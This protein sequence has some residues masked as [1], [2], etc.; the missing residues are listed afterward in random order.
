MILWKCFK[1]A[2]SEFEGYSR[3]I[4]YS[5]LSELFLRLAFLYFRAVWEIMYGWLN[6]NTQ[7]LIFWR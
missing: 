3:D 2:V 4:C 1:N 5:N 7:M 6:Y